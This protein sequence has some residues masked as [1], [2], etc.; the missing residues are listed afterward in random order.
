MT[1]SRQQLI[2]FARAPIVGQCKT[3]LHPLLGADL[4]TQFYKDLLHYCIHYA[5]QLSDTDIALYATPDINHPFLRQLAFQYELILHSQ[6]GNNLGER[7]HHAMQQSLKTYERT[8]LIGSDCLEL[9]VDDLQSA[10]RSLIDNDIVIGPATDGGYVL[11]GG[12]KYHLM[13]L[14]VHAGAPNTYCNNAP[15]IF[16]H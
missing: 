2:I 7:M 3:R 6:Y 5:T 14:K 12:K 15:V 16:N 10:F 8:L 1:V 11:I 9:T 13:F 4:S